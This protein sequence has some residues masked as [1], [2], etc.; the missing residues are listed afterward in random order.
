[1]PN[2]Y[3][4]MKARQQK[5]FDAFPLGAAFSDE[6]FVEMM[7]KWGLTEKDTD[8]IVTVFN[9]CFVR[10]IDLAEFHRLLDKFDKEKEEAIKADTTGEGFIKDMFYHELCNHEYSYTMDPGDTFDALGYT[11]EQ[12]LA[13]ARL[14]RG[15]C[16]AETEAREVGW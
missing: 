13:D 3:A 14:S 4:E 7:N 11:A 8:K 5:E 1:M 12:I 16:L 10:K 9:G 6:Q 15:F 2:A